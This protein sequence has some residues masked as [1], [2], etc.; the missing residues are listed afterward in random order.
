MEEYPN[1]KRYEKE[2]LKPLEKSLKEHLFNWKKQQIL[3]ALE[4]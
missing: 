3:W 4:D 2:V 1:L